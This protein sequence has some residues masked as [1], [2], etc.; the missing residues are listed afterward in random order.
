MQSI[1]GSKKMAT[2]DLRLVIVPCRAELD[3]LM[4]FRITESKL[5]C[6]IE[7]AHDVIQIIK[8]G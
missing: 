1:E 7:T 8:E 6:L 4:V 5:R 2:S 3:V